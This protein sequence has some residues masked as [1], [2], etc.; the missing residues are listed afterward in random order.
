MAEDKSRD[1]SLALELVLLGIL[2]TLWGSSYTFIK[3]GVETI[4]PVTL[5]AVRTLIAAS[6][7][8]AIIKMRGLSLPRDAATWRRFFVQACLNS[9]VPF[10]LIAWA[11]QTVDAGL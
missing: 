2:S 5:I 4:P 9:V 10:T 8:V 11:E 3:V 7:L 1:P 6:I